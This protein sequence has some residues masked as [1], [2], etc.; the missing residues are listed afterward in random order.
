MEKGNWRTVDWAGY[1]VAALVLVGS[2]VAFFRED[3]MR[4]ADDTGPETQVAPPP[5]VPGPVVNKW[6]EAAR[7]VEEDRGEKTGRSARVRVPRELL[8]YSDK[9]RF[10]AIQVAGWREEN[11]ELPHDE[12]GLA[13]L[14]RRGELVEVKPVTDDYVLYGVGAN[15]SGEPLT[16]FD[17]RTGREV[18]LYPRW[19]VFDDARAARRAEIEVKNAE[20]E[21]RR[22]DFRK[23]TTKT[24]AGRRRRTALNKEVQAGRAQVAAI[25][26]RIASEAAAYDSYEKRK[27]LVAEWDLLHEQA[28]TF[29]GREYD[30]DR[31]E[32]RRAFR[33]RLLSFIR[34][35]ALE[36]MNEIAQG[37]RQQFGRPLAFTSLVRSEH[38]QLQLG[39]TNSNATKIAVPPHTTGL[40]FDIFYRYM[41]ADEQHAI[42]GLIA[43][44]EAEGRLEALRE[45]RDH[46]HL[47]AF[48]RGR[49]P[50]EQ[51][52]ADALGD[53]RPVRLA[54]G[55]STPVKKARSAS[56]GR[57]TAR[58][59]AA[60]KAT[61]SSRRATAKKT[62]VRKKAPRKRQR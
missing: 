42:M 21:A 3:L 30:L 1:G 16:H 2:T 57:T 4:V 34:P 50:P 51:L 47:F 41:T 14:I 52:I 61:A 17:R 55:R 32:H 23:T 31:P 15:A 43:R 35:E 25:Q 11:Y 18:T 20:I 6:R 27:M 24:R 5:Q 9:R 12:A 44:M 13:T 29:G 7:R 28:R 59:A 54:S 38:Y 40:A 56:R 8:H 26:R 22:A 62:A 36:V 53:V 46:Y 48:A 19:D 37:Y 45:N 10:L 39:E 33:A 49:R 60:R 58:P